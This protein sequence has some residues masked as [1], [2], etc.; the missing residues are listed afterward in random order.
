MP[1][2]PYTINTQVYAY[3]ILKDKQASEDIVQNI[4]VSL[5]EKRKELN[6]ENIKPY[7]FRAVRNRAFKYIRDNKFTN[8]NLTRLNLI[9]LSYSA[10]KK[11]EYHELEQAIHAS[12]IKLPKRCREIFELSRYQ[13]KSHKEISE[14]LNISNQAIKNQI[15][16]ALAQIKKDLTKK[17]YLFFV[18]YS[19]SI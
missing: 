9:E 16:K 17:E 4:F 12:V 10:P 8:E 7:L 2:N 15:S 18:L 3:N 5:W 6:I 1:L 13:F 19:T 11:M 14:E